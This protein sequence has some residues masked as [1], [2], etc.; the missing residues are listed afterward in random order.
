MGHGHENMVIWAASGV[1][2][3]ALARAP[4]RDMLQKLAFL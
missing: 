4:A 1:R 3:T 2:R